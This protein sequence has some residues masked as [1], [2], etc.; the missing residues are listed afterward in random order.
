ML[1]AFAFQSSLIKVFRRQ[2][3]KKGNIMIIETVVK[4]C[5]SRDIKTGAYFI[6]NCDSILFQLLIYNSVVTI[7]KVL[8]F[9]PCFFQV[10][11]YVKK[12][13][14]CWKCGSKMSWKASSFYRMVWLR[15]TKKCPKSLVR[16]FYC[17]PK[18]NSKNIVQIQN[19]GSIWKLQT[20]KF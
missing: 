8:I 13:W 2:K 5:T 3:K 19:C 11:T 7:W 17:V 10:C 4:S 14:I 12:S 18:L 16:M 20:A 15:R 6:S 1:S 9:N